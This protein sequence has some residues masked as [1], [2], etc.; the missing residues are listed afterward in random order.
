M[1]LKVIFCFLKLKLDC[2]HGLSKRFFEKSET[3][4]QQDNNYTEDLFDYELYLQRGNAW[5]R[6]N[7]ILLPHIKSSPTQQLLKEPVQ[8]NGKNIK[9]QEKVVVSGNDIFRTCCLGKRFLHDQQAF[10]VL[11]NNC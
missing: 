9:I 4:R 8:D 5:N 1:G 6:N 11:K 3:L 7:D 2:N 10:A